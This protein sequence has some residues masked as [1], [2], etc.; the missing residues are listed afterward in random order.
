[1]NI[2]T[3]FKIGDIIYFLY[4]NRVNNTI[5]DEIQVTVNRQAVNISYSVFG[6]NLTYI[7]EEDAFATKEELVASL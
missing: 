5:V 1:M 7:S 3:K 6:N 2:E 4:N